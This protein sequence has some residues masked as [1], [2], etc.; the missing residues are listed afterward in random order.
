MGVGAFIAKTGVRLVGT[1]LVV[2]IVYFVVV[3]VLPVVAAGGNMAADPLL[4]ALRRTA[5]DPRFSLW[6]GET[7]KR[8]GLDRPLIPDQLLMYLRNVVVFEFGISVYTQ[9]PVMNEIAIRLPYTLSFYTITT[10]LP[11][12]IGFY[13]G[14]TAAKSRG[15][16]LDTAIVQASIFT[17]MLPGWLTLLIIYYTLA[18]LPK[19]AFNTYIF[20]LPVRPPE[21]G[22][23]DL[24]Q[25]RYLLWYMS[26]MLLAALIAWSGGWIYYIRQLVVSEMGQDYVTTALAKGLDEKSTLRKHVIPNVRPPI[27]ISLAYTIPG[28]FGGAII[29]EIISNWPGVAYFSYQALL[30]WDFPVMSAFFTISAFLTVVSLFVAEMVLVAIDPRIRTGG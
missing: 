15:R 26:P 10:V 7:I 1:Y 11:I 28:I 12:V 17:N 13:L 3:R 20:P 23:R 8:F 5:E 4:A 22:I 9:K 16:P 18:Y 6:I 25:F 2:L 21:V 29:F 24:E 27:V 14:I 19:V 30:N